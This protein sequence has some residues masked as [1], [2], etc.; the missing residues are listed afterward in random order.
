M[1]WLSLRLNTKKLL[2]VLVSY[3][4]QAVSVAR[5]FFCR[6][7][8]P[9]RPG[10]FKM[11]T[12]WLQRLLKERGVLAKGESIAAAEIHGLD[13]NRGLTGETRRITAVIRGDT[14]E[15]TLY[16]ILKMSPDGILSRRRV[17]AG[18]QYREAMFYASNIAKGLPSGIIP[19][20][21][22]SYGSALLGEYTIL[23]KDIKKERSGKVL[24][25]NF[26][27]GNQVWG[28]PTS[29][30]SLVPDPL[31][32]LEAMYLNAAKLH[33]AYWN[34]S[35][36]L[37]Y[38]WLR[39]TN[40][41]NGKGRDT[42][43][44]YMEHGRTAWEAGKRATIQDPLK[45]VV[46]SPKLVSIMD[47]SFEKASWVK[48][49]QRLQDRRNPFTLCHSDFHAS[50]T[51]LLRDRL[52]KED[53]AI[54]DD[55]LVLFDWAEVGVWEPTADLAQTIIS[56]VSQVLFRKHIRN[57]L[58]K[59]WRRLIEFGVSPDEYSFEMCWKAFLRGGVERWIGLFAYLTSLPISGKAIQYFHDQLLAF[60][61]LDDER[62]YYE[63][64]PVA[65]IL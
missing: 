20:V 15:K 19:Q 12:S 27:F 38:S 2:F 54:S 52:Y 43:E 65:C 57:L 21:L 16:L 56:D 23:M 8:G 3:F 5:T 48:L 53:N 25:T 18:G 28:V 61:E 42:W 11:S 14:E 26:V 41:Y 44:L 22:Y 40:W 31:A 10:T 36:L 35:S 29:V 13:D 9:P 50:N 60:I 49:V 33:V 32:A 37:R 51:F 30:A 24:E 64:Q 45:S 34:N 62:E 59:Y 55:A 17:I 6:G 58:E 39:G 1:T 4:A 47:K 46:F 63:L 7:N